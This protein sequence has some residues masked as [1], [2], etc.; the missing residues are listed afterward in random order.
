[1]AVTTVGAQMPRCAEPKIS[2]VPRGRE[3]DV[4]ELW[5]SLEQREKEHQTDL[6]KAMYAIT[7]RDLS[8]SLRQL[9]A[10]HPYWR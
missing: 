8:P 3:A 10:P 7:R 9:S 1:M 2:S 6:E 5:K 4:A